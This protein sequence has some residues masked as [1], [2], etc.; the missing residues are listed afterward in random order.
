MLCY[1]LQYNIINKLHVSI[2]P[3][4]FEPTSPSLS[5]GSYQRRRQ[6]ELGEEHWRVY[7]TMC[8]TARE[9]E[10]AVEHKNRF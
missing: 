9:Q 1:F 4:P 8:K 7:T 6:H 5:S 2:N 10:A 3:L